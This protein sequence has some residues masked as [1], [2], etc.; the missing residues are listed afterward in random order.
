[1]NKTTRG[2]PIEKSYIAGLVD[3]EGCIGVYKRNYYKENWSPRYSAYVA[4]TNT[5]YAVLDWVQSLYGGSLSKKKRYYKIH[6]QGYVLQIRDSE[7]KVFLKDILPYLRIK[8]RQAKLV[9]K[10]WEHIKFFKGDYG[11]LAQKLTKEELKKRD[12]YYKQS[13]ALNSRS[14]R[15]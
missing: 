13:L 5:N 9:I 10:F 14:R 1:M 4:I 11:R 12:K 8:E 2:K 3:G 15:D 7:L 6:K